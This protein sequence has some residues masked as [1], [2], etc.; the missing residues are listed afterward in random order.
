MEE[1]KISSEGGGGIR[2]SDRYIDPCSA[3]KQEVVNTSSSPLYQ[4]E[5]STFAVF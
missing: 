3:T 1:E 5:E 2:F 4:K